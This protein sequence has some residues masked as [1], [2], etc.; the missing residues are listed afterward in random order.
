MESSPPTPELIL[1]ATRQLPRLGLDVDNNLFRSTWLASHVR[2]V[3]LVPS[4]DASLALLVA[5]ALTRNPRADHLLHQWL[6]NT[7]FQPTDVDSLSALVTQA[8]SDMKEEDRWPNDTLSFALE[9]LELDAEFVYKI[10]GIEGLRPC[11]P[12]RYGPTYQVI[13][14]KPG[15]FFFLQIHNES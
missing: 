15:R 7:R 14:G 4:S 12:Y 2:L 1:A 13:W 5:H 10:E 8:I 11:S 3:E 6:P 9:H